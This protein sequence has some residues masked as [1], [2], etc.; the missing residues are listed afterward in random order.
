MSADWGNRLLALASGALSPETRVTHVTTRNRN[1]G[2]VSENS[3]VTPVTPVTPPKVPIPNEGRI[4]GVTSGVTDLPDPSWGSLEGFPSGWG[5]ADWQF[6]FEERSAILEYDEGLSRV[7]AEA[8]AADQIANQ[9][10]G[11]SQ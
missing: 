4:E 6:A 11:L 7:D 2:Y 3:I 5:T 1:P 10:R 8:L 9:R